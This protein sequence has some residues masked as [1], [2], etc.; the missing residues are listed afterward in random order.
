MKT[1]RFA[2]RR[3][4]VGTSLL[5]PLALLRAQPAVTTQPQSQT[6]RVGST[7]FFTVTAT[8]TP[9]LT[10][11]WRKDGADLLGATGTTC[12][13]GLARTN[14]AGTYT[15]VVSNPDGSVTSAVATL[16][17][18]SIVQIRAARY[19]VWETGRE[20]TIPVHRELGGPGLVTVDYATSDGT[21][22]AGQDYTA[23]SG[24]LTFGSGETEKSF[25]IPI[26]DDALP[27]GVEYLRL[28]LSGLTGPA[29][30]GAINSAVIS[31]ID[32]ETPPPTNGV[33]AAISAGWNHTLALR[34]DGSLWAWGENGAGQLGDGTTANQSDPVR[35]GSD[36]DWRAV[37]AGD[38]YSL[39]LK[40][41]GSLWAWGANSAGQLGFDTFD[42]VNQPTRVDPCLTWSAIAAG[43]DRSLAIRKDGSLWIWGRNVTT[44]T[45][46]GS[47]N[48]WRAIATA[49]RS[50]LALKTDGSLW[51][52]DESFGTVL[53]ASPVGADQDWESITTGGYDMW[54]NSSGY[55]VASKANGS[56]LA[57]GN[58]DSGQ[59]GDGTRMFQPDPVRI[60]NDGTIWS[61]G[62]NESGQLGIP[63]VLTPVRLGTDTDW[64]SPP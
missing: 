38:W 47:G 26:L 15:V 37:A 55:A 60:G 21:A 45:R 5:L 59:L 9:P 48:D 19:S 41:D 29:A 12:A 11:Q 3:S 50:T 1:L 42:S 6:V 44:P 4:L 27:E 7:A 18:N 32:D 46:V 43:H 58:N 63:P 36:R 56:L 2:T 40:N 10:Y 54:D 51:A 34:R 64:G 16:A 14:L 33:A 31:L 62:A 35:I 52:L 17:V 49:P 25:T 20:V 22:T 28:T 61:W 57:W 30:F 39:A 24:T 23:T 8:G 13:L 53:A